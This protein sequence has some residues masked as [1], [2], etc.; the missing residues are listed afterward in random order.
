MLL[1]FIIPEQYAAASQSMHWGGRDQIRDELIQRFPNSSLNKPRFA[2]SKKRSLQG[3]DLPTPTEP[4]PPKDHVIFS[5]SPTAPGV[6]VVYRSQEERIADPDRLN[7]DRRHLTVCPIFEGEERL[8]LLNLQHNSITRLQHL[9][10]LRRLVFLDL[11][12]NMVHEIMGLE[13]LLS[14]RV[15]MLGRNRYAVNDNFSINA[16]A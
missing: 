12:D 2:R 3:P 4:T 6:P 9:N 15:L 7:L 1:S 14:L 13:G 16:A 8:R 5:E 11:Y 10:N